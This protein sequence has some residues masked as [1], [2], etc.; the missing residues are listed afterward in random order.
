MAR[1]RPGPANK[2]RGE[3]Y[4]EPPV[5]MTCERSLGHN[6]PHSDKGLPAW[7][8]PKLEHLQVTYTCQCTFCKY[9][10]MMYRAQPSLPH[11]YPCSAMLP[12]VRDI[13]KLAMIERTLMERLEMKVI[14]IMQ[15]FQRVHQDWEETCY[16]WLARNFGFKVNSETFHTLATETPYRVLL[17]SASTLLQ[18]EALL[19]GQAGF[20][21]EPLHDDYHRTLHREY[22]VLARKFSLHKRQ[23]HR[24]HWHFLRLRPANF[25]TLRIAQFASILHKQRHLFAS[26]MEAQHI[27]DIATLFHADTTQYWHSHYRFAEPTTERPG[28]MGRASIQNV[29]I[30]T[31]VPM[32]V[33]YGK[34]NDDEA[35]IQRALR[36]LRELPPEENTITE[37][38]AQCGIA[39]PNAF[40]SQGLNGMLNNYCLR[41]RCLECIIGASLVRPVSA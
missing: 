33:A 30:N 6:R 5:P 41:R 12:Q 16:R 21:D 4:N 8:T 36:F 28:C 31:V 27:D 25:P 2:H 20:L 40:D 1:S 15:T 29:I 32:L 34:Y 23:L 3:P 7:Q 37:Q 17:R 13:T 18:V 24:S 11:R 26:L 22:T 19:F 38:W 10:A 39:T 35:R 14:N 9:S